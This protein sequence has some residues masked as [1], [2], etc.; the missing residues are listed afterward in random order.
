MPISR[1]ALS[2]PGGG[3]RAAPGTVFDPPELR[4]ELAW[5]VE[6]LREV[7]AK[8]FAF[9]DERD[10]EARY[11]RLVSNVSAP[12]TAGTFFLDVAPL[13]ASLNDGH[14]SIDL[15]NDYTQW[16][17]NGGRAFPLVLDLTEYGLFVT[18]QTHDSLP[19]GSKIE[20][21]DGIGAG[22]LI[23]RIVQL[24]GA[25]TAQVRRALIAGRAGDY[26]RT[27]F[28]AASG[29]RPEFSIRALSPSGDRVEERVPSTTLEQIRAQ[30]SKARESTEPNYT[31]SRLA[32]GRIGYIDYR[33]CVDLAAFK[34]FL[35][36]TFGELKRWPV[37]GIVIDIRRNGGGDS[38][39][40]DELWPYVSDR[41]FSAGSFVTVKV[42][43]RLKREYGFWRYNL[44]YLPPS[45][46]MRD[47]SRWTFDFSRLA[48][49]HPGSNPLRYAGPVYLLIG[50][51][52]FSSALGC[53][54]Q[55]KVY[56]LATIVGQ[57]TS[58]ANHTG[59][60]YRGFSPRVGLE[61]AFTTKYFSDPPFRDGEGVV[62]DVTIVPTED[63]VR[64][65]ADPVL[66]YAV[67]EILDRRRA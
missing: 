27:W 3:P 32:D 57:E 42:S 37:D 16:R 66:K 19:V 29:E 39:L 12:S 23:Q 44:I 26:F 56:R 31:F 6:T 15:G 7:S 59:E 14:V 45:W 47:G 5:L 30:A 4:A 61:F 24:Q 55:A 18:V 9:S 8:P 48:T 54:E 49:K 20:A 35:S 21:I 67:R 65:G 62:P 52:T 22:T 50:S 51:G 25:Q 2:L 58:P 13:F 10:F 1:R 63:D 36:Q 40:N 34:R 46:I 17:A 43:S 28:Y 38:R 11:Q 60:V 41:P 53:A 64:S 33:H